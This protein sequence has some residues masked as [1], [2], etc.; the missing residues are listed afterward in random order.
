MIKVFFIL[1][2]LCI[3]VDSSYVWFRFACFLLGLGRTGRCLQYAFFYVCS[4]QIRTKMSVCPF[5]NACALFCSS[6]AQCLAILRFLKFCR[7]L[8]Q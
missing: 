4:L 7:T 6:I 8:V 2:Y 5:G 1:I 3:P